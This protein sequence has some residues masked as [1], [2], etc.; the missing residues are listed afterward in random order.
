[1]IRSLTVN[2]RRTLAL[3]AMLLSLGLVAIAAPMQDETATRRLWDTDY[4]KNKPSAGKTS[5]PKRRYRKVTPRIPTQG[6]AGDTVLGITVWRLR[7][8][9]A[10]DDKE[11]RI[12]RHKTDK[13]KVASW[14][15]VRVPAETPL[16]A[17]QR[18]RLSIEAAR[19]GYL[20][21]INREQYAD[22]SVGPPYLIF[23]TTS[24]RGG[25]NQVTVGR[26]ID[27]PALEDEP[28][29]FTLEPSRPDQIGEVI[30]V[31][32]TPK[33][34]TDLKLGESEVQLPNELVEKWEKMWGAKV[35]R[36]ELEGGTGK[37]WTKE[38][39]AASASKSQL[40]KRDGP[41]PQTLYYRPGAKSDDPLLVSLRLRYGV[42][43]AVS[44]Q[45]RR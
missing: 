31:I 18:V 4:L 5:A 29:Y 37:T 15:P 3:C 1:M 16:P 32:V 14:T 33:P 2:L 39:K 36:L 12:I 8:S 19:S 25:D 26:I 17:G 24:L 10:A 34:L 11:V 41:S 21:V 27:L 44:S 7:A 13:A 35:G 28:N 30:S 38:E 9:T 45:P 40:L 22:G 6:V 43:K 42:V 23:P 20:Y